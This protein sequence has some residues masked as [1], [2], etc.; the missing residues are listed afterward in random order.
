MDSYVISL[1]SVLHWVDRGCKLAYCISEAYSCRNYLLQRR[2]HLTFCHSKIEIVCCSCCIKCALHGIALE[3]IHTQI[4]RDAFAT[5]HYL[6]FFP[7]S[8]HLPGFEKTKNMFT[9]SGNLC[10]HIHAGC[11]A[12][13][14][15]FGD[16]GPMGVRMCRGLLPPF[17]G[18]LF[19]A[20][21]GISPRTIPPPFRG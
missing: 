14:A 11:H 12:L 1:L 2:K 16:C 17:E 10:R 21:S 15:I 3:R 5:N 7:L 19:Q 13:F 9:Y 6:H 8:R 20:S 18:L 4:S